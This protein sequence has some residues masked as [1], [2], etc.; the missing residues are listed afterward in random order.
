MQDTSGPGGNDK[1]R[2]MRNKIIRDEVSIL[3]FKVALA[4]R[5]VERIMQ[6]GLLTSVYDWYEDLHRVMVILSR[7][8]SL[9]RSVKRHGTYGESGGGTESQEPSPEVGVGEDPDR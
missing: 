7:V 5:L 4:H 1:G 8:D 3:V 9:L 2:A 6:D